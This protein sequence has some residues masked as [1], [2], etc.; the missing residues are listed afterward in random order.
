[1]LPLHIGTV[2][3]KKKACKN[4]CIIDAKHL[5]GDYIGDK[6]EKIEPATI[7]SILDMTSYRNFDD[8]FDIL[9]QE[10]YKSCVYP[11]NLSKRKHYYSKIFVF[12]NFLPDV[13][14][15]HTS[16]DVRTNGPITG[17]YRQSIEQLGGEPTEWKKDNIHCPKHFL[18]NWG[19]FLS[20]PGHKQGI[21]E[22]NEMLL[23]YITLLRSEELCWYGR[24]MGHGEYLADGIMH[25]LHLCIM[26]WLLEKKTEYSQN[27]KYVMYAGHYDGKGT[28]LRYW[29]ERKL[30]KP[31]LLYNEDSENTSQKTTISI[32]PSLIINAKNK[33]IIWGTGKIAEDF[34]LHFPQIQV[35]SFVETSASKEFFQDIPVMSFSIYLKNNEIHQNKIIICSSY[36]KEIKLELEKHAFVAYQDFFPHFIFHSHEN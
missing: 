26:E 29:K 5:T 7:T 33:V 18:M 30:F 15:I 10:H 20:K 1:M 14:N 8:Y 22:T 27:I 35:F 21:L 3:Y 25:E 23:G 31:F 6:K 17:Y 24:I 2:R 32:D 19:I 36:F 13:V 11:A 9:K 34:L 16:K 12:E 4:N 28:G